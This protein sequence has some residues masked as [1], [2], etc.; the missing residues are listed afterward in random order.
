MSDEMKEVGHMTAPQVYETVPL[1]Q[2]V[3]EVVGK[4]LNELSSALE[5]QIVADIK[6]RRIVK[7]LPKVNDKEAFIPLKLA[8]DRAVEAKA[9]LDKKK[10]KFQSINGFLNPKEKWA[11]RTEVL[12]AKSHYKKAQAD[13]E[14][15][16]EAFEARTKHDALEDKVKASFGDIQAVEKALVLLVQMALDANKI[17][18][19]QIFLSDSEGAGDKRFPEQI[20]PVIAALAEA[21]GQPLP[22]QIEQET[23]VEDTPPSLPNYKRA[24]QNEDMIESVVSLQA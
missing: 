17:D 11:Q 18:A 4:A 7:K 19:E 10:A 16:R 24:T 6:M 5:E 3:S 9:D 20:R 14:E 21:A 23:P 2:T 8:E 22:L 12:L 13:E 15:A 1:R